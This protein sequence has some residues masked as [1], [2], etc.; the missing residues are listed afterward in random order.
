MARP[1]TFSGDPGDPDD[2]RGFNRLAP[3]YLQWL[4]LRNFS[5][6][7]VK[8]RHSLLNAFVAWC[9]E[10]GV[11]R[12]CQVTRPMLES[13]QRRLFH[14][15]N[16]KSGKHLSV[17]GQ[18][19]RLVAV[20][21]LFRWLARKNYLLFNPASDLDLPRLEKRLPGN[22]LSPAEVERVLA[23]PDTRD[24]LGLRDRAVLEAFYSTGLRRSELA[25]LRIYDLLR[26]KGVIVV[27]QGKGNKDRVIPIGERALAW[28]EK[29]LEQARPRLAVPPDEGLVFL[30]RTGKPLTPTGLSIAVKGYLAR[31]GIERRGAC[32]LFRHSMAT[33]MLDNGADIRYVQE[34]LGH[35]D[36]KT[37]QIYTHVSIRK[38][39]EIHAATHPARLA[40]DP[41][42]ARRDEAGDR[43]RRLEAQ[44]A[45][46]VGA[47]AM[48]ADDE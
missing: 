29:Y 20:R 44:L 22:V 18:H 15:R 27:N 21:G 5:P 13:Y 32:H 7:T 46:D 19:A 30:S 47:A 17:R 40:H 23:L 28:V 36:L 35:A 3:A 45:A 12:P 37:T 4:T 11:S 26:D 39:K 33:A 24:P 38:L 16:P 25:A 14:Y 6:R 9:A 42:K 8:A 48:A 10:R 31:A 34:M 41:A 1:L 43:A 2:P